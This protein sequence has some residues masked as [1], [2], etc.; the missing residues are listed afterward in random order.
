M[1]PPEAVSAR[2]MRKL[3]NLMGSLSHSM[4]GNGGGG[5]SSGSMGGGETGPSHFSYTYGPIFHRLNMNFQ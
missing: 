2:S 4:L 1:A 3:S 5:G